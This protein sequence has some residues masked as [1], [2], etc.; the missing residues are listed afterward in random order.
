[1][2]PAT[3]GR[4]KRL[5]TVGPVGRGLARSGGY[6][7][8]GRGLIWS[9]AVGRLRTRNTGW[10]GYG[11]VRRSWFGLS[12]SGSVHLGVARKAVKES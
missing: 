10:A 11:A 2:G 6:G 7:A 1:V 8:V 9:G 12:W 5:W 3:F 4:A